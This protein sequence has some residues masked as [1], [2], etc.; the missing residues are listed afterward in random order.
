MRRVR[1]D[2]RVAPDHGFREAYAFALAVYR[3]ATTAHDPARVVLMGD[4]AGGGFALGLAQAAKKEALPPVARLVLLA[5]WL[6]LALEN[7]EIAGVEA[8]DPWLSRRGLVAAGKAWAR[9]EPAKLPELSP[10]HGE[11]AGLPPMTIYVG[12]RDILWPDARLLAQRARAAGAVVELV[13]APGMMHVYPLVPIPEG[14]AAAAQIVR[15]VAGL[16]S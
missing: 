4:S 1:P 10:I 7:P 6:D 11:L 8:S 2:L 9:G 14:R 3:E 15:E 13:E 16:L 5:P 12:T